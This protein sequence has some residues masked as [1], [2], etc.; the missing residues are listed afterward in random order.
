MVK[1]KEKKKTEA[2]AAP[3]RQNKKGG[4]RRP[5]RSSFDSRRQ[6]AP[7]EEWVPKTKLGKEVAEGKVTDIEK[8]FREGRK[9]SEAPIF[10][11]LLPNLNSEIILA[12]GSTGKGGGIKR[13]S[14]KRTTRMHK[15]GRRFRISVLVAAGNGNGYIGLELAKGPPGRHR[16][17]IEKASRKAK[18]RIIP[19]KRGCGSWECNCGTPHSI[20]YSVKG[21]SGS[22]TVELIPA[23]KGIGLCVSDEIKKMMRLAGINDIW[24]KSM[25]NTKARVN[26]TKAVFDALK[27]LNRFKT[28]EEFDKLSGSITGKGV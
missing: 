24:C 8:V 3:A 12:G 20:P 5:R 4:G 21:R 23:P 19:I 10:D 16:D 13:T 18:L 14:F 9:I 11:M 15:S 27:K 7:S 1:A 2:S 28:T 6:S 26:F 22:V 17:V 25:G